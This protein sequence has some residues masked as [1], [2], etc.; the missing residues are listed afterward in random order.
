MQE[1]VIAPVQQGSNYGEFHV[2]LDGNNLSKRPLVALDTVTEGNFI[3][4]IGDEIR[5]LFE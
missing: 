2:N 5:L 4:R 1:K 3:N